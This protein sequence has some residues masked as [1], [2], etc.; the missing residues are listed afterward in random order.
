MLREDLFLLLHGRSIEVFGKLDGGIPQ[1]NALNGLLIFLRQSI[2]GIPVHGQHKDAIIQGQVKIVMHLLIEA[3]G[4]N[5]VVLMDK[6]VNGA[7]LQ[8]V[9]DLAAVHLLRRGAPAL[10]D[11]S[12]AASGAAEL[13]SRQ[14]RHG[15]HL[16]LGGQ[17]IQR[18]AVYHQHL[19]AGEFLLE[20]IISLI[21]IPQ[22]LGGLIRGLQSQQGDRHHLSQGEL[23]GKEGGIDPGN[24]RLA[25][26]NAVHRLGT[27]H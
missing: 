19:E 10:K 22:H 13:Q 9:I 16:F 23:A 18:V 12:D 2:P 24:I 20:R 5:A 11:L 14:I 1:G 8:S 27:L 7:L 6:A 3:E 21:E 17:D 26:G 25:A 4:I 15:A